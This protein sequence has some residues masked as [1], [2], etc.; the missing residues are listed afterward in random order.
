MGRQTTK[1]LKAILGALH[2]S[3]FAKV[4][5]RKSRPS[6]VVLMLH[7][8]TPDGPRGF[9]PNGI[10]K[11]TP[12]FLE[13]VIGTVRREGF[14]I[15]S[16]DEVKARLESPSINDKPFAVFTLDDGYRDNRDFAYPIFK[17]HNV[18]F[19][20]YVPAAYADGEGDLWWLVL[21]EALRLLPNAKIDRDGVPKIY[22][23]VDDAQKTAAFEDIYWWLRRMP[24]ARARAI[25]RDL[26]SQA[27]F[28]PIALCRKLVMNWDEIR[29]LAKDPLVTI[30][31]H[32]CNHFALAKLPLADATREMAGSIARVSE[33]LGKPC[34]HFSYPYGDETSAGE[35]EF[36]LAESLGL[37]T[38]VTTRK[39]LIQPAHAQALTALPRLSLN[40]DFQDQRFV[41][42]LL[43]G[44][45]FA[46]RDRAKR[47]RALLGPG[48]AGGSRVGALHPGNEPAGG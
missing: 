46:L 22:T 11:V 9:E 16:L 12:D 17:R 33:E 36:E 41:S 15:I 10:L 39:G 18:P 27:G 6:G 23:L 13:E 19:T 1:V 45:P 24:E 32:T 7:H 5:A 20:I 28:D 40:G 14:E 21:E 42:V 3:G 2:Y 30:A 37:E 25:T 35:R 31:A 43:S 44:L 4:A 8:V 26:A 47:A 38:A 48:R 34:R 29:A